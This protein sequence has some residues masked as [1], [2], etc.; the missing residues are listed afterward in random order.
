[1]YYML[2]IYTH[3]YI[4]QLNNNMIKGY[5]EDCIFY[6]RNTFTNLSIESW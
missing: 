3:I 4:L 6:M 5:V 2:H 1:M